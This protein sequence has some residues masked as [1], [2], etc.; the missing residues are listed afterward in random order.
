M[1]D[2]AADTP[3]PPP[4]LP[5]ASAAGPGIAFRVVA[6]KA[7]LWFQPGSRQLVVSFDNL[8]TVDDAYPRPPWLL[9]RLQ[10][11][12]YAVLGIQTFAKDWYRNPDA[13]PL[14]QSLAATGFFA[15]FERVVFIGAS[16]GAFAAIN[17]ASLVPGATVIAFSPQSTM[18]TAIA[19]FERRFGWAVRKGDWTTPAFLDA[20]DAVPDVARII[21]LYDGRVPEDLAH[22]RRLTAPNVQALR[23]D[24]STHEAVRVVMKCGAL[25]PLLADVMRTGQAGPA[26]WQAMRARRT[27][28]KWAR[29]LMETVVADAH[30]ARIRATATALLRQEDYLF[31]QVALRDLQAKKAG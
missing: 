6:P 12:G 22:A 25:P 26:F 15:R 16:M 28:R 7:A 24:H 27:V 18:S 13:A 1:T 2:P 17:L 14:V 23:V 21:L 20:R 11:E 30:P 8:A 4:I 31:A 29:A 10:A 5:D 3:L 9:A 19:P